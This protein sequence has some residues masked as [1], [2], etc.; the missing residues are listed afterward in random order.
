MFQLGTNPALEKPFRHRQVWLDRHRLEGMGL[1]A[2]TE[3]LL[4]I[5]N[6]IKNLPHVAIRLSKLISDAKSAK[7]KITSI[8][9]Q[10][11]RILITD[12][13]KTNLAIK[14]FFPSPQT[15]NQGVFASQNAPRKADE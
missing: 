7:K 6:N 12:E 10:D 13:N 1:M 9:L 3:A 2:T 15:S 4:N 5:F 8:L 14:E 11:K